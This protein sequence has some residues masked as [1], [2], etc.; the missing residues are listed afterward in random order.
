MLTE[1]IM[2]M[3]IPISFFVATV[4][5]VWIVFVF[6]HR[7]RHDVQE[8][9][10]AAIDKGQELSPELLERLGETRAKN[11]D[12]RRGIILV[13]SGLA[14]AVFGLALGEEDAVRPMIA[15]GAFPFLV[16]AAY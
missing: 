7:S 8:T 15:V 1:E 5:V 2:E 16:G 4:L 12:L 11:V 14:F 6:R 13:G 9:Y 10:R 3:M